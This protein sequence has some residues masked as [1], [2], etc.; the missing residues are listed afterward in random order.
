MWELGIGVA[1]LDAP[2]YRG[3]K[4]TKTYAV[5]V[6][7][8]IYR[9]ERFKVDREG[10]RGEIFESDRLKLN[11][12][13]SGY[14]PVPESNEGARSGM[15]GLDPVGE[16]GPSL[17]YNLWPNTDKTQSLWLKM[18]MRAVI[19]VGNHIWNLDYQGWVF[20]PHVQYIN[21]RRKNGIRWKH[22]LSFGP[23]WATERYHDYYYQV[24]KEYDTADRAEY[25][26]GAGYS[27]TRLS[28]TL[29]RKSDQLFLGFI[30][31][32]DNLAGAVFEDSPLVETN[33]YLIVAAIMSWIFSK[34]DKMS[35]H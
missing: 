23:I 14:V 29:S 19:S 6:P 5:P 8:A 26:P 17:E 3:S 31:R 9:G 21:E 18:P 33:D 32:Y 27:G 11:I 2:H 35:Q 28:L 7:F 34:S 30:L 20:A 25:H 10:I 16:V 12:S 15:P 24:N 13:M 1:A 4:Q 22:G